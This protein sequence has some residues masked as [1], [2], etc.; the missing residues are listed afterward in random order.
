MCFSC[1]WHRKRRFSCEY[2]RNN[3]FRHN[4]YQIRTIEQILLKTSV[5]RVFGIENVVFRMN[6]YTKKRVDATGSKYAVLNKYTQNMCFS[7][8]WHQKRRFSCEYARNNAF[9]RNWKQIRGIK[10]IYSKHV[11]FVFLASKTTFFM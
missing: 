3:A 10:Q 1:F 4:C 5:F 9:R 7:C 6:M 11:F 8:I 2:A